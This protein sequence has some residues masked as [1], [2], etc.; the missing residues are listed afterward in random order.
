MVVFVARIR[1]TPTDTP[2]YYVWR[3]NRV[4]QF[5]FNYISIRYRPG[6]NQLPTTIPTIERPV[7]EYRR[8][9]RGSCL[10]ASMVPVSFGNP[11]LSPLPCN[12]SLVRGLVTHHVS[13]SSRTCR[14]GCV[15]NLW[16]TVSGLGRGSRWEGMFV[17]HE[18][19]MSSLSLLSN[20]FS[21]SSDLYGCFQWKSPT[22]SL[23]SEVCTNVVHWTRE[24]KDSKWSS[25]CTWVHQ[26]TGSSHTSPRLDL[27]WVYVFGSGRFT[28]D[29][30]SVESDVYTLVLF[31]YE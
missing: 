16:P 11:T 9:G 5:S 1:T 20:P 25:S 27:G 26:R 22:P 4:S 7:G 31:I 30:I 8:P 17:R 3:L 19:S 14:G 15:S 2:I 21:L 23:G 10:T 13:V 28:V 24:H 6:T 18:L 29:L 12:F